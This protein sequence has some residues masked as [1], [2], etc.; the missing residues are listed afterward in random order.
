M[1]C[2]TR[3]NDLQVEHKES[4]KWEE[5]YLAPVFLIPDI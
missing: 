4:G 5:E 1:G 3:P 2:G